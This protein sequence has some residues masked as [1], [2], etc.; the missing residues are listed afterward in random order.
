MPVGTISLLE[1]IIIRDTT[2]ITG[3]TADIA[4]GDILAFSLGATSAGAPI[5]ASQK[6]TC[7]LKIHDK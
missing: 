7:K 5:I 2:E 4:E 3:T 1:K 6:A